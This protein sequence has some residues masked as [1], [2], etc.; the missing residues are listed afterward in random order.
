MTPAAARSDDQS[1][2]VLMGRRSDSDRGLDRVDVGR[3]VPRGARPVRGTSPV[4]E[5]AN[6]PERASQREWSAEVLAAVGTCERLDATMISLIYFRGLGYG[7]VAERL[8]VPLSVVQTGVARGMV[9]LGNALMHGLLVSGR[10]EDV[11][12]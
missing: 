2:S 10:L 4:G 3:W 9:H 7:Q 12:G 6:D 5:R 8:S 11:P 1:I